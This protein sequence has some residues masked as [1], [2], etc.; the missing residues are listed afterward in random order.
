M[1]LF[2]DI[3]YTFAAAVSSPFW[4][5]RLLST[6][7][8]RTDW[9]ARFGKCPLPT[10]PQ[11]RPTLLVHAVS[12]GEVNAI[13]L[14]VQKF[15]ERTQGSWRIVISVTTD[16]GTAR[17]KQIFEPNFHVVRYPLDFTFSVKRF[18]DAVNPSLVA[19][20]EL[21]VWP[22]FVG[23]CA[24]RGIPVCVV[25]GRLTAR[26]YK[27]YSLIRSLLRSTFGRLA[28][29][30]VQT[31]DYA[32]RFIGLGTPKERVQILDT[33]KWDTAQVADAQNFPGAD[34]LAKAMGIDRSRPIIVAGSTGPGEEALLIN[35]CPADA[36][37]VLVPRKPE[38]FEE[39][40]ALDQTMIRR[41]K[42]A[43]GTTRPLDQH[44]LFLLDTMGELRKAYALA[45]V[46]I[47]GRSFLGLYG[48]DVMEPAA[49]G[50]PVIIGTHHKDFA[51]VVKALE[52]EGGIVVTD[53]PG[54]VAAQLLTNRS[55]AREL[56]ESARRVILSRQG[57]TERH[58]EMLM[59]IAGKRQEAR[60]KREE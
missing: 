24:R 43:D 10:D 55:V 11:N 38:R 54:E 32:E 20:T 37:L 59:E 7:K 12:V 60:G 42:H 5:Y 28:A 36:Q 47:V 45:D 23:H 21:E 1:S 33:M 53:K 27:R 34:E 15:A 2:H 9:P 51:N 26:S 22:N 52:S 39:V 25:N 18:L 41:T 6:G 44:R 50:K 40:A 16:T 57:A 35:T 48:S 56:A 14:L 49:L 31:Q 46:V 19:L 4:I 30:G 8:W 58:V 29:A 13:R 17:A 3:A